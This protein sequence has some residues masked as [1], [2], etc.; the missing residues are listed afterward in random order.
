MARRC[1]ENAASLLK[2]NSLARVF[3][4][5]REQAPEKLAGESLLQHFDFERL[6]IIR[7]IPFER[8]AF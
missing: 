2:M 3:K 7:T 8:K 6:K 5:P 1:A 4:K